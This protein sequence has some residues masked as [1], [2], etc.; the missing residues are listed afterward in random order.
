MGVDVFDYNTRFETPTRMINLFKAYGER[1]ANS[2]L[3][4]ETLEFINEDEYL[5]TYYNFIGDE[6]SPAYSKVF[7]RSEKIP[8][9]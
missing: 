2:E 5:W 6:A 9:R 4:M 8:I 7:K 1:D 3:Q